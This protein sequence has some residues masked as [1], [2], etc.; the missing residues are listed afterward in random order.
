MLRRGVRATAVALVLAALVVV[1]SAPAAAQIVRVEPGSGLFIT[2]AARVCAEYADVMANKARN[3]IM[4]SLR[5]LG[6]STNYGDA[7]VVDPA[8]EQAGSP[9]CQPL[10]DWRM[11]MGT[12]YVGKAPATLELS[13]VTSAYATDVVT[14]ASTPLLSPAGVDTGSTLAGAVTVQLDAAQAQLVRDGGRIWVQGGTPAQPLNGQQ[15]SYG[16]AALRCAQDAVNGDNVE[17]VTF[18][19]E[20]THVFCYYYAVTPPPDAGTITIRKQLAP[21]EAGPVDF[22]FVGNLSYADADGDG[23]NDFTLRASAGSAGEMT[24]VRGA[25]GPADPAWEVAELLPA[26]WADPGPPVCDADGSTISTTGGVTSIRLASGSDVVCTYTNQRLALGDGLLYKETVG[27]VGEFPVTITGPDG[28]AR[29][30]TAVVTAPNTP[31]LVATDTSIPAGTY[32]ISEELPAPTGAGSWELISA[33]C[34]G[35]EY[36]ASVVV[37]GQWRRIDVPVPTGGA[38]DCLWINEYTPAGSITI[39][40]STVGDVGTFPYSINALDASG[41]V[42]TEGRYLASATTSAEGVPVTATAEGEAAAGISVEPSARFLVQERLPAWSPAGHW[43]VLDIDCGA[44]EVSEDRLG[45][46]AEIVLTPG[47]PAAVCA[48]TNEWVPGALLTVVKTT[49]S[50]AGLRPD[51]AVVQL[52]CSETE[53]PNDSGQVSFEVPTGVAQSDTLQLSIMHASE[54][55]IT[56]PDTGAADGVSVETTASVSVG[57]GAPVVLASY[58][59]PFIVPR[60]SDVVVTVDNVLARDAGVDPELAASGAEVEAPAIA[61]LAALALGLLLTVAARPRRSRR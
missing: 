18:P 33:V 14:Q 34:S 23:V 9:S 17:Y 12:G 37:D 6:P 32:T 58:D 29:S 2:F 1:P 40:K 4:E 8:S 44:N 3:N 13:T 15:T 31:V 57:G 61:G 21:G 43:H 55:R 20:Q 51:A 5:D 52:S 28:F 19:H 22:T 47:A 54:C 10:T 36:V 41:S 25:V 53:W 46:T 42:V 24:F 45:A 48:F 38:A 27:G 59:A 26:G 16:F 60:G 30:D 7:Q 49:S 56:E 11:T 50:D 35:V 39:T